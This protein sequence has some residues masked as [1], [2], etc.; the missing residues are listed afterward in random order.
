[1]DIQKTTMVEKIFWKEY[2]EIK[3]M[4]AILDFG[5]LFFIE[6]SYLKWIKQK[7]ELSKNF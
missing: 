7:S 4:L 5:L 2:K 6:K 1:M 3:L